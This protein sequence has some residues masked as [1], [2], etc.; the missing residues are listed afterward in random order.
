M[1]RQTAY[2]ARNCS[3]AGFYGPSLCRFGANVVKRVSA[4]LRGPE[5][6]TCADFD[7]AGRDF[8]TSYP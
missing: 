8:N 5:A 3:A 7:S 2:A 1:L 6:S 4:R